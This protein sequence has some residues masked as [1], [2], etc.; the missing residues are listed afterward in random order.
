MLPA[1]DRFEKLAKII[2]MGQNVKQCSVIIIY[3]M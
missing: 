3:A 1:P 2:G